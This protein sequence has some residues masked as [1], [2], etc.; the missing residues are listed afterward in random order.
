M[1]LRTGE[2]YT[3][4]KDDCGCQ[5]EVTRGAPD[6]GGGDQAPRC[7]CGSEMKKTGG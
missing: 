7:C 4:T 1:A 6:G 3:C 2:E 5:I